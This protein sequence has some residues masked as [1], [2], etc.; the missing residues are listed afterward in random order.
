M[1]LDSEQ[2]KGGQAAVAQMMNTRLQEIAQMEALIS[3]KNELQLEYDAFVGVVK[4]NHGANCDGHKK[5][6]CGYMRLPSED[7]EKAKYKLQVCFVFITIF[8]NTVGGDTLS[9]SNFS[10]LA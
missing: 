10:F 8:I 3:E 7:A 6:F 5:V 4:K 1:E 9:S 2:N